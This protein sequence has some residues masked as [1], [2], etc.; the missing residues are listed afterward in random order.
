MPTVSCTLQLIK[1]GSRTQPHRH[2]SNSV[3]LAVEGR[4]QIVIEGETF[5]WQRGDVIALP[6][7][8]SHYHV[9]SGDQDGVLF[10]TS[11]APLYQSPGYCREEDVEAIADTKATLLTVTG[12]AFV[13]SLINWWST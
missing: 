5:D 4:G 13:D 7:W 10:C 2:I 9:N 3:Y 11:D 8:A 1:A 12:A 6:I